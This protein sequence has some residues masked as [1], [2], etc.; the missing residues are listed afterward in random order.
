[1]DRIDIIMGC[2]KVFIY[3]LVQNLSHMSSGSSNAKT[4]G[5]TD[6]QS[7]GEEINPHIPQW[8]SQAPWYLKQKTNSLNHQRVAHQGDDLHLGSKAWYPRGKN[9]EGKQS[10][11]WR[12]GACTNC[13]A[14]GHTAKE[15]LEHPRKIGA[16]WSGVGI[17]R[18]DVIVD[19]KDLPMDYDSKRDIWNGYHPDFYKD[20]HERYQKL[21]E[22]RKELR[23]KATSSVGDVIE[24]Q[25]EHA[26]IR[27]DESAA[28]P[29]SIAFVDSRTRTAI[30]N[31]RIREDTAKYLYN[32]DLNSAYYDP[33]SR[34]MHEDP[35][36]FEEASG[37]TGT[38]V[39]SSA[40]GGAG[41]LGEGSSGTAIR[42]YQG[43]NKLRWTGDTI[44]F[45]K[46]QLFSLQA[47]EQ[48]EDG[49]Q[50]IANP[51]Q[52]ELAY[53]EYEKKKKILAQQ[54]EEDLKK[55][56]GEEEEEE[57]DKANDEHKEEDGSPA[58]KGN[59]KEMLSDR[60]K[61][62]DDASF[63]IGIAPE[64]AG[65]T[66]EHSE[67]RKKKKKK[68]KKKKNGT[69]DSLPL[70]LLLGQTEKYVEYTRDGKAKEGVTETPL[71]LPDIS[72][73]HPAS[74]SSSLSSLSSPSSL[75]ITQSS[76]SST[77]SKLELSHR[78]AAPT[79]TFSTLMHPRHKVLQISSKYEEDVFVNNHTTIYGSY[80]C[81][82][83]WGYACCHQFVRGS[84]CTGK[85]GRESHRNE[86][87]M[88][89][90][91]QKEE[92]DAFIHEQTMRGFIVSKKGID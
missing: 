63:M 80:Y 44:E 7:G 20:V 55:Q 46:L 76:S 4:D 30:R 13:G 25:D 29:S 79:T 14:M 84:V 17:K 49:V 19:E 1:M 38:G 50:Y 92:E 21:D 62:E 73:T 48:G 12:P 39:H 37:A 68:K 54:R 35:I 69:S 31:L 22:K 56:Y 8:M 91:D 51:L 43:D 88:P 3:L 2:K 66:S 87:Q 26:G 18:D 32:L 71:A 9:A 70:E 74:S 42:A 57:E 81:Q 58:A 36:A 82:G 45:A 78:Q 89:L 10:L 90:E 24:D 6:S 61:M 5:G 86:I 16:K 33:K 67:L 60:E 28:D 52:T 72:Q 64:P 15:C 23:L 11:K 47:T 53:R 41:N 27:E 77:D 65:T 59:A 40:S 75:S 34:A 83:K 85:S